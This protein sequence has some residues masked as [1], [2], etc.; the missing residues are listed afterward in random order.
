M[1]SQNRFRHLNALAGLTKTAD[2]TGLAV[3]AWT[4]QVWGQEDFDTDTLHDNTTNTF[5]IVARIA[6]KYLFAASPDIDVSGVTT[7]TM[8]GVRFIKN[9][10]A[11][12]AFGEML[13]S[14]ASAGDT[15]PC[16]TTIINLAAGDWAEVQT[17][18]F[19]ASGTYSVKQGGTNL[20]SR[21]VA[22]YLGE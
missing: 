3:N 20:Y 21:F 5:L 11:A 17:A 9:S 1:V 14:I 18:V 16:A 13:I 10:S 6:G 2:Q 19:G 7:P 8:C 4:T 12:V 22:A 15:M